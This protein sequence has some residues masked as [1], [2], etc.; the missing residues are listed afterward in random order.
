MKLAAVI[1]SIVTY[2]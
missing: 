1:V 2:V